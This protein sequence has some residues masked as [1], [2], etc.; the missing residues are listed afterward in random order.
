MA[1]RR[2]VPTSALATPSWIPPLAV[3]RIV[4][5]ALLS[6][7]I[8]AAV[9][10]EG[11][12]QQ[13]VD[14]GARAAQTPSIERSAAPPTPAPE[15]VPD[16]APAPPDPVAGETEEGA[17]PAARAQSAAVPG[18]PGASPR[19]PT[20]GVYRWIIRSSDVYADG[21]TDRYEDLHRI[22]VRALKGQ[23]VEFFNDE[24]DEV[25]VHTWRSNGIYL[26]RTHS[27]EENSDSCD[28]DPDI[29]EVQTP[30]RI[31]ASWTASGRCSFKSEGESITM[32]Q[33]VRSKVVRAE[34]LTIDDE[35]VDVWV[36]EREGTERFEGAMEGDSYKSERVERGTV[37]FS[38][39]LGLVVSS[40][41][42]IEETQSS[43]FEGEDEEP[44][45][46]DGEEDPEEPEL[47][48]QREDYELITTRPTVR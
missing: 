31:G 23:R 8:T 4:V 2:S 40:S 6:A 19:M 30:L 15:A 14:A 17:K 29:L 5:A 33:S 48:E 7:S 43:S 22:E 36:I 45:M 47:V 46:P 9:P 27:S 1:P 42:R 13:R 16:S 26:E 39:A 20:A 21:E 28:W 34:R 35:P 38:P 11:V 24:Y 44:P 10:T 3:L 25:A 41:M 32:T 37:R 18:D 12:G